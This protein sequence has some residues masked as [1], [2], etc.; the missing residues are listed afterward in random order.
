M[1][2]YHSGGKAKMVYFVINLALL[3]IYPTKYDNYFNQLRILPLLANSES[4]LE[5]L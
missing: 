4:T 3:E 5:P 2:E 1:N